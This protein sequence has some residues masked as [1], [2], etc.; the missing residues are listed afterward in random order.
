MD[1]DVGRTPRGHLECFA[2]ITQAVFLDFIAVAGD[3]EKDLAIEQAGLIKGNDA[4]AVGN[5]A[6]LVDRLELN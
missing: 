6:N 1:H 3:R 5:I 4:V 2:A